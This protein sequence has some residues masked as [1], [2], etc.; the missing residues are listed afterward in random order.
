[1]EVTR[2]RLKITSERLDQQRQLIRFEGHIDELSNLRTTVGEM[3][4]ARRVVLDIEHVSCINSLGVREWV[5]LLTMLHDASIEVTLRRCSEVMVQQM[6]MFHS[7]VYKVGVESFQAPY[8]CD[9]CR[10]EVMMTIDMAD[11]DGDVADARPPTF[12]CETCG[13]ALVFIDLPERYFLFVQ[14]LA[15]NP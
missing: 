14:H 3:L 8:R 1:M 10:R 15:G 12:S 7:A 2:G 5:R 9:A 6:N 11:H 13:G 4:V